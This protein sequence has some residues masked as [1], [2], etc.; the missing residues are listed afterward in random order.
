MPANPPTT[1]S[2]P[3]ENTLPTEPPRNAIPLEAALARLRQGISDAQEA[4][5]GEDLQF[6]IDEVELGFQ[7]AM[8]QSTT[9]KAGAKLWVL[10]GELGSETGETLTQTVT[11]KLKPT[12]DGKKAKVARKAGKRS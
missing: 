7:V 4:A 12:R 2:E 3:V 9:E 6:E 10:S 8:T 11:F 1:D 5:R